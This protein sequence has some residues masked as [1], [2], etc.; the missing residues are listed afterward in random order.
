MCYLQKSI[1]I[2]GKQTTLQNDCFTRPHA[3]SLSHILT[4]AKTTTTNVNKQY[5][6]ATSNKQ[7]HTYC[8]TNKCVTTET[9]FTF[10]YDAVETINKKVITSI[11]SKRTSATIWNLC[12]LF[13]S[14]TNTQNRTESINEMNNKNIFK[15]QTHKQNEQRK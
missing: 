13:A 14:L 3:T 10:H 1:E 6:I 15:W 2:K 4:D 9:K 5:P 7:T 8:E 11:Y 12:T